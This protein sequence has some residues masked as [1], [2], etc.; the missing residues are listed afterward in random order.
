MSNSKKL[1]GCVWCI[2][3]A[4]ISVTKANATDADGRVISDGDTVV[5]KSALDGFHPVIGT[6]GKSVDTSKTPSFLAPARTKL[7]I[8]K[9]S[10]GD[11][12]VS[13]LDIPCNGMGGPSKLALA[14][15]F[16]S[17]I[18]FNNDDCKLSVDS[19]VVESQG[20][21]VKAA[22]L[23]KVGYSKYGFV[24]GGFIVPYKYFP[25]DGSLEASSTLGPFFGYRMGQTGWGVSFIISAGI[26]NIKTTVKDA[27]G[28]EPR[29]VNITAFSQ[30]AGLMFDVTKSD[31]PFKVGILSGKDRV[32]T[33]APVA[34][35]HDGDHWLAIQIGW[36]FGQ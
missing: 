22:H 31:T 10:D 2:L 32:G 30:A 26:T 3:L 14:G 11:V 13:V 28:A 17:R 8:I 12:Y 7:K 21:A 29:E 34:Y 18:T 16:V 5:L 15:E 1:V 6:A 25:S 19:L 23:E 36:D 9:N 27:A 4:V 35:K 20:Y 33:N 24:Y